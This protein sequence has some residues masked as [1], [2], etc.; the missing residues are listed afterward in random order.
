ML[1]LEPKTVLEG[2]QRVKSN[3]QDQL[4]HNRRYFGCNLENANL[5][6]SG[7]CKESRVVFESRVFSFGDKLGRKVMGSN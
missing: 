1:E 6:H 2:E 3:F 4:R 5:N 7:L